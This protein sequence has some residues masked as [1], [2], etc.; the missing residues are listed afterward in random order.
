MLTRE[1]VEQVLATVRA[2]Y[3]LDPDGWEPA[4]EDALL[5]AE[6]ILIEALAD[7]ESVLLGD[8]DKGNPAASGPG[9]G[10][11]LAILVNDLRRVT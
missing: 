5:D 11:D 6:A 4:M 3:A 7:D 2:V 10:V 1:Q 8:P 9:S